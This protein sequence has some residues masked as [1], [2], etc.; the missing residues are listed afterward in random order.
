MTKDDMASPAS[1]LK[2]GYI[3]RKMLTFD[4][5]FGNGLNCHCVNRGVNVANGTPSMET[6]P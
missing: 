6:V 2:S 5:V 4:L 1:N 3:D